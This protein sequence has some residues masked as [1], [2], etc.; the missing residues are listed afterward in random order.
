MVHGSRVIPI[1][2]M[3]SAS[4][5]A[6]DFQTDVIE[7]LAL[8]LQGQQA[9]SKPAAW[10][11]LAKE[12][13]A[14]PNAALVEKGSREPRELGRDPQR[15]AFLAALAAERPQVVEV[16][17]VEPTLGDREQ[18]VDAVVPVYPRRSRDDLY[19]ELLDRVAEG[20]VQVERVGDAAEPRLMQMVILE[21]H[22]LALAL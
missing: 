4:T 9:V 10:D 11:A 20:E 16:L 15:T 18:E 1:R 19:F 5:R 6:E 3:P 8:G 17:D 12:A 21:A 14:S 7:G 13:A 22:K 2:A